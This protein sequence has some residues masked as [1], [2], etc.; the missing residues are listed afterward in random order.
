MTRSRHMFSAVAALVALVL[1]ASGC[2]RGTSADIAV[3][4]DTRVDLVTIAAPR[5]S[6]PAVDITLGIAKS[7]TPTAT[8]A[9]AK[10]AAAAA[11]ASASSRSPVVAGFLTRVTVRAGDRVKKG[12]VL[13]VFDDRLLRLGT[14]NARAA[15][16]RATGLA[17]TLRANADTLRDTR[18]TAVSAGSQGLATGAAALAK[19]IAGLKTNL[20]KV[21][22]TI[23]SLQPAVTKL[24]QA[25]P[26]LEKA[27]AQVRAAL[28]QAEQAAKSPN[29]P[30][31]IQQTIA[32]LKAQ[33]A[34]LES[35]LAGLRAKLAGLKG[36]LVQ[37]RKAEA[38]LV[39]GIP[40]AT[41][42]GAAAL[43][44]G[45]AQLDA[46]IAKIDTGIQ[47]LDNGSETLRLAAGA[48]AAGVTM[49]DSALAQAT[50][51]APVNGVVV[52]AM[53]GGQVALV[54]APVVVIRPDTATLVDTYV[55]PEDIG[56]V[57]VGDAAD[58]SMDSVRGMLKGTVQTVW[59]DQVFPP[60]N[61]PT[62]IVHLSR[63]VRVTVSVPD[64]EL[65]LGIPADV[66]IHPSS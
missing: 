51:R 56:R 45:Q 17:G 48:Q 3:A 31:G 43:A 6:V 25:I 41:A 64:E 36:A 34:A 8:A 47:A 18:D 39:A 38:A 23:A 5:L 4:G 20:A 66:V 13:A 16:R 59:P 55:A 52:S 54:G 50:L 35:Q 57:K 26:A 62:Q 1:A 61:Y 53:A 11:A 37:L 9:R 2:S 21:R 65:P 7:Q 10:A 15:Y 40:K 33:L 58:V 60:T 30:P 46:A 44:K 28:T 22:A 27:R 49:A 63:V 14:Q 24:Q 19:A 32:K 12:Q 29:P 42:A